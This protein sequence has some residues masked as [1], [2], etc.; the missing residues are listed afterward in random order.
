MGQG[1]PGPVALKVRVGALVFTSAVLYLVFHL[2]LICGMKPQT[3]PMEEE[4][5]QACLKSLLNTPFCLQS[6]TDT[7]VKRSL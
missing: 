6:A 3:S 4:G 2:L 7:F 5:G 1:R